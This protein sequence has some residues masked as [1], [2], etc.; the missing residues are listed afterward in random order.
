MVVRGPTFSSHLPAN[1]AERPRNT[2]ARLK[3]Q[4]RVVSFQSSGTDWSMPMT[5][6]N[7][8]LK[9]LKAYTC[10]MQR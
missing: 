4:P 8:A 10:P 9:T 2:M 3:V 1:A 5:W 7:G 6:V